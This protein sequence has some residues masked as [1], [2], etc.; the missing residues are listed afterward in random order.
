MSAPP[1]HAFRLILFDFD[2][3]L[4]DSQAMIAQ[5]MATAFARHHMAPP[6]PVSVRRV[7]GLRLEDAIEQ[8]LEGQTGHA[9]IG[10]VAA[11]YKQVFFRIRAEP[12]FLEPMFPGVRQVL[13]RLSGTAPHLGIATGKGRRGLVESLRRHRLDRYFT[14]LKTADDGP[15][16]PNPA[17]LRQ[18]MAEVGVPADETLLIGDTQYDVAM[19]KA[20]G[21]RAVGAAWGYHEHVELEAAGA[22]VVLADIR[23]LPDALEALSPTRSVA[24]R[25]NDREP[26][27]LL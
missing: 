26:E 19:A 10:D 11:T 23:E 22:D 8:L 5:V 1:V 3:T 17:I 21:V 14:V 6:D 4:V 25:G 27:A 16:K 7:I 13:D 2:G 24:G 20:A 15:G 9:L 18:A 12:A